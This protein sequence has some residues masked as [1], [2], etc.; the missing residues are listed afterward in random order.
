M[1]NLSIGI[2]AGIVLALTT[3]VSAI[4]YFAYGCVDDAIVVDV[5]EDTPAR[6]LGQVI[7]VQVAAGTMINML[8]G[9]HIRREATK[10]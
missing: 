6:T 2:I 3:G 8:Y 9:T 1:R 10:P 4:M 5:G 7:W